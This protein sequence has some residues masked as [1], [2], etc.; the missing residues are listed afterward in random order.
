VLPYGREHWGAGMPAIWVG[1]LLVLSGLLVL[2][3]PR[4]RRHARGTQALPTPEP[5]ASLFR[6]S[7]VDP[8][9]DWP[10]IALV[11]MG[12]ILL[13]AGAFA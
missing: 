8:D 2:V 13:L 12:V 7:G 4:L 9:T 6:E 1:A 5:E 3:V 11:A 10:G